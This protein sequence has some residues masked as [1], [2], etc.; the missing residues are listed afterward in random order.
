MTLPTSPIDGQIS[1]DPTTNRQF[2]YS[3]ANNSWSPYLRTDLFEFTDINS[4]LP[5]DPLH[6]LI[7]DDSVG[8]YTA[9]TTKNTQYVEAITK[10]G[11]AQPPTITD[12]EEPGTMW[13]YW[14]G[15]EEKTYVAAYTNPTQTETVWFQ[16][17]GEQEGEWER[18][19]FPV[20]GTAPA[21]PVEGSLWFDNS[22]GPIVKK[23]WDG[24]AWQTLL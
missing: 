7:W 5:S 22:G 14:T 8:K 12:V 10:E 15:A 2:I 9:F 11:I 6:K 3:A 19:A 16:I 20:Q 17:G 18:P 1:V 24:S 23:Y 13:T 21:S 4:T